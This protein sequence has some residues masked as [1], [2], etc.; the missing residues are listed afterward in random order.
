MAELEPA[1][2]HLR[3]PRLLGGIERLPGGSELGRRPQHSGQLPAVVHRCDEEERLCL[4]RQSAHAL[5]ERP[6]DARAHGDRS[7]DR[8]RA[9]ELTWAQGRGELDQGERVAGGLGDQPFAHLG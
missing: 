2:P 9:R 7:Q 1:G 6:L 5:E 4:R 8:L 3:K